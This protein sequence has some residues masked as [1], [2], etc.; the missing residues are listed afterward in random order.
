MRARR[1][2]ITPYELSNYLDTSEA[3]DE[4]LR[5]HSEAAAGQADADSSTAPPRRRRG[6]REGVAI[7]MPRSIARLVMDILYR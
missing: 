6:N 5:E 3:L 4:L 2:R 1:F 7:K